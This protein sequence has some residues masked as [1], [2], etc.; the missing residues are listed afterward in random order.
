MRL[1]VP[2]LTSALLSTPVSSQTISEEDLIHQCVMEKRENNYRIC[3]PQASLLWEC[4]NEMPSRNYGECKILLT[5]EGEV[6]RLTNLRTEREIKE[7]IAA[8]AARNAEIER[9]AKLPG[10]RLG[11][12]KKTVITKTHWGEP[13]HINRTIT[14]SGTR[15]QWAY[16]GG[17]YLYFENGRLVAIQD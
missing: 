14:S 13:E 5:Q 6:E 7:T 8:A 1:F 9:R 16:G 10:V 15:E 17:S 3:K 2:L 11:M 4:L 12:S